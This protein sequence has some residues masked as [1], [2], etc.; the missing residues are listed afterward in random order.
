L[1]QL[2][3]QSQNGYEPLR[4]KTYGE[5]K[6]LGQALI[7]LGLVLLVVACVIALSFSF[8]GKSTRRPFYKTS[9]A[10][11]AAGNFRNEWTLNFPGTNSKPFYEKYSSVANLRKSFT[12]K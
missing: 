9:D 8:V 12:K 1:N 11:T 2:F 4:K 5:K 6:P 10:L 3:S 7:E